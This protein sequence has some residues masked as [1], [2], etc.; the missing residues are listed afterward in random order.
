MTRFGCSTHTNIA[1]AAAHVLDE[2]LLSKMLRQ[3]LREQARDHIGRAA[4]RVGNDHAHRAIGIAL[5]RGELRRRMDDD[6]GGGE[7]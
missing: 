6:R 4:R 3:P 5:R 2:E 7:V 1:A